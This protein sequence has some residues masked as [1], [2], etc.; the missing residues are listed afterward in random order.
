MIAM[1]WKDQIKYAFQNPDLC[2]K[3]GLA[4]RQRVI[5]KWSWRESAIPYRRT[6]QVSVI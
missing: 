3:I 1:L 6:L 2:R 4:G 5:E